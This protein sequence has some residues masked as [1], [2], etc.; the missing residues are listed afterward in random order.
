MHVCFHSFDVLSNNAK[1]L[2]QPSFR[3][4]S[5]S[6]TVDIPTLCWLRPMYAGL[7]VINP[8]ATQDGEC[9]ATTQTMDSAQAQGKG[10]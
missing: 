10:G 9:G 5:V 7:D 8:A 3:K 6:A 2:G 1:S 4:R